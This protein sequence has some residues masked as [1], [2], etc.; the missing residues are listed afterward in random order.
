M[1][2]TAEEAEKEKG[3][4]EDLIDIFCGSGISSPSAEIRRNCFHKKSKDLGK[5]E[6]QALMNRDTQDTLPRTCCQE[7][8]M[9]LPK[10]HIFEAYWV[11]DSCSIKRLEV[12]R[13]SQG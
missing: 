8:S 13:L 9:S 11:S 6:M 4:R 3:V 7:R 12:H 1:L 5:K 10:Y 2:G